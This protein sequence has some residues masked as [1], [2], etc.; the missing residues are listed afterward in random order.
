MFANLKFLN[1]NVIS[2]YA[3]NFLNAWL[4]NLLKNLVLEKEFRNLDVNKTEEN[5][6]EFVGN[7]FFY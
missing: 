3:N 1:K 5:F 2:Y 4:I 7:Y 6:D